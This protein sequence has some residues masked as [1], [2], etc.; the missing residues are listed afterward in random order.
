[1]G[2]K[3]WKYKARGMLESAAYLEGKKSD[4]NKQKKKQPRRHWN[5][6][7][8]CEIIRN[9]EYKSKLP[10]SEIHDRQAAGRAH[11]LHGEK[12]KKEEVKDRHS[13]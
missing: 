5:A 9:V 11:G 3:R 2:Q 1:M 13:C 12:R 7:C 4:K 8:A 6:T 10:A